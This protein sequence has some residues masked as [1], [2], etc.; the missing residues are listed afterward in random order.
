M[1]SSTTAL[2]LGVLFLAATLPGAHAWW[3]TGHMLVALIAQRELEKSDPNA[4]K[5]A[6]QLLEILKPFTLEDNHIFAECAEWPDDIKGQNWKSFNP[7]HFENVAIVDPEFS[8]D[9]PSSARNA[10][11]ALHR[12]IDTIQHKPTGPSPPIGDLEKSVSIRLLVHIVGDIHQPLHSTNF[13]SDQFPDGDLGG[14]RFKIDYPK[15]KI[16]NLHSYWDSCADQYSELKA[17][18]S[19]S[20]FTKLDGYAA[21]ITAAYPRDH[22]RDELKLK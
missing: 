2:F 5:H 4:L 13:F 6:E 3:S 11:W 10:S 14:N 15:S 12:L 21:N 18:L 16:T 22:F 9:T 1:R 8:G 19:D 20:Q 17:P 7:L